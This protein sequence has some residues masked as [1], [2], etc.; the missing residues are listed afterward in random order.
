MGKNSPQV[1]FLTFEVEAAWL[2]ST[3]LL[4]HSRATFLYSIVIV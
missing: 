2:K 1:L 4:L 3:F